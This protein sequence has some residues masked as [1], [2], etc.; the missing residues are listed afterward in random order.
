M[1]KVDQRLEVQQQLWRHPRQQRWHTAAANRHSQGSSQQLVDL[2]EVGARIN[3][4]HV[5][6]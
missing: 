4:A 1:Q 2:V 5:L 3:P 6:Q